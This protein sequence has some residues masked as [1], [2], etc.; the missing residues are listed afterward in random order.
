MGGATR[1]VC[2]CVKGGARRQTARGVALQRTRRSRRQ[3]ARGQAR[4]F[5]RRLCPCAGA[6][7]WWG[8]KK[9]VGAGTVAK[10]V[11][12]PAKKAAPGAKKGTTAGGGATSRL[13]KAA[14]GA[15]G[16]SSAGG[17]TAKKKA[18]VSK[19]AAAS[20][21]G[22]PKETAE[23]REARTAREAAA[24][25]ITRLARGKLARLELGRRREA[26]AKRDEEMEEL[27]AK[28]WLAQVREGCDTRAIRVRHGK[29]RR[30]RCTTKT[31]FQRNAHQALP[32]L[33]NAPSFQG[34]AR[35]SGL[36][37]DVHCHPARVSPL[38]PNK[39]R[40]NPKSCTC[41]RL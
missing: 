28:A 35:V 13:T 30:F 24:V 37:A 18:G 9:A 23:E 5:L 25:T 14:G 15:K 8:A 21:K 39:A 29:C 11:A 22:A 12:A 7:G 19:K 16:K 38:F 41:W 6:G 40:H 27:R 1:T 17:V 36:W 20:K 31:P 3:R 34:L 32:P 26:K 4:H 10:K 2:V 33:R